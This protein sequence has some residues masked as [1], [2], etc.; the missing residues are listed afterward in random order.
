MLPYCKPRFKKNFGN[1][2]IP[3]QS[4]NSASFT[5]FPLKRKSIALIQ[6]TK[7]FLNTNR[8][9]GLTKKNGNKK[10]SHS[11]QGN[12]DPTYCF[13]VENENNALAGIFRVVKFSWMLGF[14]VLRSREFVVGSGQVGWN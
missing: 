11:N 14:A 12:K 6:V 8:N 4:H 13:C 2:K 9:V 5:G 3:F 10:W 7:T 1:L